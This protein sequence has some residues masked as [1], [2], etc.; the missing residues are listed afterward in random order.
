[1]T[2]KEL[3]AQDV[4]NFSNYVKNKKDLNKL[5]NNEFGEKVNISGVEIGR[6]INRDKSTIS[7]YSFN[8]IVSIMTLIFKML[9]I[10]SSHTEILN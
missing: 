6:I 3:L 1:M 5:S 8:A 7:V 10:S 2:P 9:L 4:V